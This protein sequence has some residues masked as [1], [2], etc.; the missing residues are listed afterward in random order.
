MRRL[1]SLLTVIAVWS[2]L[3][4]ARD[5]TLFGQGDMETMYNWAVA[6]EKFEAQP[7]WSPSAGSP[8]LSI[9]KAVE[10]ADAWIKKQ[11]P[12]V[13]RFA[14]AS[15]ALARAD[16]WGASAAERWYYRIEFHPIVGGRRLYGGQFV[17]V[18]LFDGSV[19]E[20]RAEKRVPAK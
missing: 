1:A 17:A 12:D 2:P 15:I 14:I 7:Q 9:A 3:A 10:I 5:I 20:P 6:T 16:G 11:N 4:F 18:V 19:V 13:K 8:P